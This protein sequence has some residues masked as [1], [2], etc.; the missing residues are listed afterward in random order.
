MQAT[1]HPSSLR[2][3]VVRHVPGPCARSYYYSKIPAAETQTDSCSTHLIVVQR[4]AKLAFIRA[5]VI[6]HKIRVLGRKL[7]KSYKRNTWQ[8]NG[9]IQMLGAELLLHWKNGV[10]RFKLMA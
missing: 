5:Q 6:F 9:I 8:T 7:L 4:E 10:R 2:Q 1:T 3:S